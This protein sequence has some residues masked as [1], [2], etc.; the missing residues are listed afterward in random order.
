MTTGIGGRPSPRGAWSVPV[1]VVSAL[2]ASPL[3]MAR[4]DD[5][6]ERVAGTETEAT[7]AA[8]FGTVVARNWA[9]WSAGRD[10]V[11]R[12]ELTA[13]MTRPEFRAEDAA[14]LAALDRWA[15]HHDPVD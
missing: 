8:P 14:A 15:A 1:L 2:L 10:S 4:A 5:P 11:T 13:A 12:D 7:D 9:A 6:G 3:P